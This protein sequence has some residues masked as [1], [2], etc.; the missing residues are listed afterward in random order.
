MQTLKL[1]QRGDRTKPT[2]Y[3]LGANETL[4]FYRDMQ[5][6]IEICD[7]QGRFIRSLTRYDLLD[8]G[9]SPAKLSAGNE[10]DQFSDD[11]SEPLTTKLVRLATQ[12]LV[13]IVTAIALGAISNITGCT[14]YVLKQADKDIATTTIAPVE[15]SLEQVRF[16]Q[17][18]IHANEYLAK[19]RI[20]QLNKQNGNN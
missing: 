18:Q 15:N 8:W 9:Y 2:I 4:C 14:T 13:V 10:V 12:L 1:L 5:G 20:T 11:I 19:Q 3:K 16:K 17:A 7:T 6:T